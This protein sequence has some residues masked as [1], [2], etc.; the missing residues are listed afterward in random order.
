[1]NF[2]LH[3]IRVILLYILKCGIF[4][5]GFMLHTQEVDGSSPFVSTRKSAVPF[6]TADFLLWRLGSNR[7]AARRPL[8]L[9]HRKGEPPVR[10][11]SLS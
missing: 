4:L 7:T 11:M 2:L 6:G 10:A 8:G 5:K 1:M 9:M 3:K